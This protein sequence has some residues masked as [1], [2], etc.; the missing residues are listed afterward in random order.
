MRIALFQPDIAQNTGAVIRL[1]ACLGASV[2]IIGPAGFDISDR[3]LRRSA[4]DYLALADIRAHVSLAEFEAWRRLAGV[5]LI[6]L[7][8]RG[9]TP[10]TNVAYKADDILLLG[11]ESA[12]LPSSLLDSSDVNVRIQMQPGARSLNVALAAAMVLGEALRQIGE[13]PR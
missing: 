6:A 11:R 9:E 5:R 2:D 13:Q 8:S 12:G 3:A 1:G 10:Y 4:M 7:S